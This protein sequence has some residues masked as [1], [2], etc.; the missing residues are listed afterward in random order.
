MVPPDGNAFQP[1]VRHKESGG[2]VRQHV[3]KAFD[4]DNPAATAD[5]STSRDSLVTQPKLRDRRAQ[6]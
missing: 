2:F 3:T 6:P 1:L 4:I 5:I